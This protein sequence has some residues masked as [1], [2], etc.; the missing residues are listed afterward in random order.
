MSRSIIIK[1]EELT[2]ISSYVSKLIKSKFG[3]G[4]ETCYTSISDQYIVVHIKKFMTKIEYELVIKDDFATA[5]KIRKK[6]MADLLDPIQETLEEMC[7]KPIIEIYQDWNFRK[8]T[9]VLLAVVKP[10]EKIE[11]E[12]SLEFMFLRNEI[13]KQSEFYRYHPNE[14]EFTKI[15]ERIYIIRCA[16]YI[17]PIEKIL[18][19]K[20]MHILEER[21]NNI[22]KKYDANIKRFNKIINNEIRDIFMIWNYETDESYKIFYC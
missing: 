22:R 8:N 12:N 21:E 5:A 6:I 7:E 20:G 15:G 4:P 1:Q 10:T 16:G 3:K 19:E 18:I 14:M 11:L 9:G 17:L 2:H 13:S